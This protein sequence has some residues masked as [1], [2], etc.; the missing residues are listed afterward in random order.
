MN[1]TASMIA[2]L[3]GMLL[4][5][6]AAASESLDGP[7][8]REMPSLVATYKMLHAAPEL[9]HHERKTSAFVAGELRSFGYAVTENVGKYQRPD[10]VGYGVVALL[11]NGRGPTVLL[12]TELDGLPIEEQSGLPYASKVR[13]QDDAGQSVGAMH[14]CGHDIHMTSLLG[15]AKL[16]VQLKAQWRGTL[17]L[18]AQ[19]AEETIDGAKA[20]L[21]DGLYVRFPKPDYA[22][23]LHNC[24]E[25][26]AGKVGYC[27]GYAQA[28]STRVE[29]TVRGIGGHG[30]KPELA[31]DPI[32]VAAQIV[33][34]LQTIVSRENSPLDPA[35]VTVGSIHG[36][37]KN[38]IIPDEV[39]LQLTVRAY[40][41]EVRQKILAAIER[42]SKHVALAAGVPPQLA[43]IVKV[44][45]AGV[46]PAT[47]NDPALTQRLASAFQKALGP[48]NVVQLAPL[49]E[50]EDFG[51]FGLE[52]RQV[53]ICFFRLGVAVSDQLA[54]SKQTGIALPSL[55]SPLFAPPPEPTIRTGVKATTA[56]VL[57][58]MKN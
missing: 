33:L 32:V 57:E 51:R 48:V 12:R 50:S 34:A 30:A 4:T 46:A 43:P 40:K 18:I 26:E 52:G 5:A 22:I 56:A 44:A 28:G 17:L 47:Y 13:A 19:P 31:K 27:P 55:H 11:K 49:M 42:I 37:T 10:W 21:S 24:P 2:I 16:L 7:I 9:P 8:D 38:N 39:R 54:R 6:I 1:R 14:A 45:D 3:F 41:E 25:L 23:A 29:I 58:L 15:T 36:G 53:P 35:V 20:M